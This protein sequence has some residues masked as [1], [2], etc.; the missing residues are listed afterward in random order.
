MRKRIGA[1]CAALLLSLSL[2]GCG[3]SN[4]GDTKDTKRKF[5]N[6]YSDRIKLKDD[7]ENSFNNLM[8]AT[9]EASELMLVY[10]V[11]SNLESEAGLASLDIE[12]MQK[13]G[14]DNENIRILICTGGSNYWWNDDISADEVAIYEVNSGT[15]KITKLDVMQGDNMAD[16]ATLT[17]FLDYAYDNYEANYYSLVLW[18]H[19]GGAVLGYGGD[20]RYDYDTLSMAEMDE[21]FT[22]SHMITDGK[23]FE[24][25]GFDACLMGMI[26]IAELFEP[27]SN[28]LIASEEVIPG[29]GW[30]YEF[31]DK[32]S[33]GTDFSGAAAGKEIIDTYADYYDSYIWYKP[34]Y[35]LSCLDLSKTEDV[36]NNFNALI[37]AT[38]NDLI[39]GEYSNIAR[40][41]GNTKAFGIVDEELC[42]DT[43]DLYNLAENMSDSHLSEAGALQNSLN[44]MVVY[45]RSNVENAH[46]VAVYFP[47]D[48]KLYA[49]EWVD[50]Y[51]LTGFSETY[52]QFVRNFTETFYGAPLTAWE[53]D[54][55]D[56]VVEMASEEPDEAVG[57]TSEYEVGNI[58]SMGSF[59]IQLT[60]EQAANFA[61]ASLEIWEIYENYD[62]GGYGLWI[63]S[64]DV[65][66]SDDN[67]LSSGI[68]NERIILK[69]T[70]GNEA[71]CCARE[72]ERGD[73]YAVYKAPIIV[74]YMDENG[75][76]D[77]DRYF[78][79]YN[80]HIRIDED[81]PGGVIIGIYP[82]EDEDTVSLLPKNSVVLEQGCYIEPFSYGR[83]IEFNDDG[84]VK[85]FEEWENF[86]GLFYGFYLDGDLGV[87]MVDIDPNVEKVYV[88]NIWDT[89]GNDYQINV[90][91]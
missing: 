54:G 57:G 21:A 22:T 74:S 5:A 84:T 30:D 41:R 70:S 91:Q 38:E 32:I 11:G 64:S 82:L 40:Q 9:G 18:N 28:Y 46:G 20:E 47:Y 15:E 61:G 56:A 66:L 72:I 55:D 13:S 52:M 77:M 69:D 76:Y 26:E 14:F 23:K 80:I 44:E 37:S 58:G 85:P 86:S 71:D 43:V 48:N 81:N 59:S 25:V 49:E 19:G 68:L 4:Y 78:I 73:G 87:D 33:D 16:P 90:I 53:L 34:E 50:E 12:E 31:L 10:M 88:Y 51:S 27:Y 60:D 29:D 24:W 65:Y 75:D 8:V 67:V 6:N 1:I 3:N 45:E 83:I 17:E 63:D 39:N 2:F 36:M 7:Y 35:T 42:Y 79:P 62:N 89:Q